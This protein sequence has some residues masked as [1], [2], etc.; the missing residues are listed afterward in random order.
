LW[1]SVVSAYVLAEHEL[2]L[3]RQACAVA[4]VCD[5]L[6]SVLAAEGVMTATRLGERKV[7]PALVEVRQQQLALARLVVALR[8]PLGDQEDQS[9]AVPSTAARLQRRGLRGVYGGGAS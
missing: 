3:L 9:P 1:R 4:D 7:H 2:V 5:E 8:V 6:R